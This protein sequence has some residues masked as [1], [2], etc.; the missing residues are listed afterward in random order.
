M[1]SSTSSQLTA[2][3]AMPPQIQFYGTAFVSQSSSIRLWLI[4]FNG[5]TFKFNFRK[6]KSRHRTSSRQ[7]R[8]D[9]KRFDSWSLIFRTNPRQFPKILFRVKVKGCKGEKGNQFR[10]WIKWNKNYINLPIFS[11]LSCVQIAWQNEPR[12][13]YILC[14]HMQP[15]AIHHTHCGPPKASNRSGQTKSC[16]MQINNGGKYCLNGKG[17]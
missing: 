15:E 14:K 7:T 17:N 4:N 10:P 8:L 11:P 9:S 5:L 13:I 3:G 16:E 1:K 12:L 6:I 2:V